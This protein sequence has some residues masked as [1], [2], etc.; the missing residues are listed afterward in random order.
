MKTLSFHFGRCWNMKW[1][2]VAFIVLLLMVF[3]TTLLLGKEI[4]RIVFPGTSETEVQ[5]SKELIAGIEQ[6]YPNVKTEILY[7]G[8]GD[9]EKKL[10]TMIMAGNVPDLVMQQ[11]Y[12]TLAKMGALEPLN[13]YLEKKP[14]NTVSKGV[15]INSLIEFS[16][17]DGKIYTLP[18][19]GISYG[20]LVRTD[21]LEEAG[22]QPSDIKT[23]DDLVKVAKELTVDKDGDGTID[24]YGIAYAAGA[25]RHAWRQAYIMGYS[26]NF[27]LDEAAQNKDKFIEVLELI[28][29]LQPYMPTGT[30]TMTLKEAFQSYAMG[31]AAMMITGSFFTGNVYP[32]NPEVI[33]K[34]RAIPFPKGPSAENPWV[35]VAN[36]GWAMFS[37]SKNKDIAWDVLTLIV[38]KEWGGLYSSFINIPAR[39]DVSAE[40]VGSLAAEMYPLANAAKGNERIIDDFVEMTSLYGKPMKTIPGRVEMENVFTN[41]L[42]QLLEDKIDIETAY[43]LITNGIEEIKAELE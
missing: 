11:D 42:S 28:K 26:N 5:F 8:W 31:K 18:T 29:K 34:T 38:S 12:L 3:A 22:Y 39:K 7:I 10:I 40:Y 33:A 20:L 41:Y 27:S 16:T 4:V 13:S 17:Y 2:K 43:E 14:K 15:F 37:K 24:Q 9:L 6:K 35:P 30:I 36:A 21:L 19:V 23:W 32:I 25:H 1:F